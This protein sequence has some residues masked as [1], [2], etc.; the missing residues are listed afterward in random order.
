MLSQWYVCTQYRI[1]YMNDYYEIIF[2]KQKSCF[3][4][5]IPK[6]KGEKFNLHVVLI[7]H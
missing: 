1:D 2:G 6:E 3:F 4:L 5:K 7:G